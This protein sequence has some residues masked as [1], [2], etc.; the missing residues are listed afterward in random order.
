MLEDQEVMF[1]GYQDYRNLEDIFRSLK[2]HGQTLTLR[3]D[4]KEAL[5]RDKESARRLEQ[6]PDASISES[7]RARFKG[8]ANKDAKLV[9][10]FGD[11]EGEPEGFAD[12]WDDHPGRPLQAT[13]EA[14]GTTG[15][16]LNAFILAADR[17][18]L[19]WNST[20]QPWDLTQ[21]S[22]SFDA[23]TRLHLGFEACERTED[24]AARLVEVDK[25]SR[26][27]Q[28]LAPQLEDLKLFQSF[29]ESEI[30]Y[31]IC[32]DQFEKLT[33]YMLSKLTMPKLQRLALDY[34]ATTYVTLVQFL[35]RHAGC[36]LQLFLNGCVDDSPSWA[37]GESNW[38]QIMCDEL[39]TGGLHVQDGL[40]NCFVKFFPQ[41][42]D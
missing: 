33:G 14:I 21:L 2:T 32:R 39:E 29:P 20:L 28:Q 19:P 18:G 13:L 3:I 23:L 6:N 37:G 5:T 34:I 7:S 27:L 40:A 22:P 10:F 12:V 15:V 30:E 38:R 16:C 4:D 9:D 31:E 41:E 17:F 8:H 24:P 1:A 25:F 35:M 11:L 42:L 26:L 36:R